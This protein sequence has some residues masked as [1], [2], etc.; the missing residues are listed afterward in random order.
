MFEFLIIL[1]LTALFFSVGLFS[2][3]IGKIFFFEYKNH[4]LI[5]KRVFMFFSSLS[6]LSIV[7]LALLIGISSLNIVNFNEL[8]SLVIIQFLFL[9]F[10]I[11]YSIAIFLFN[12]L[13]VYNGYKESGAFK[14]LTEKYYSYDHPNVINAMKNFSINWKEVIRTEFYFAIIYFVVLLL[15]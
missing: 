10:S 2:Y 7:F 5:I 13:Y 4:V 8:F 1:L 15:F 12:L 11:L 3:Y 14:T 6:A 9:A